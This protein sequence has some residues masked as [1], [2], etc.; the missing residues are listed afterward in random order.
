MAF[1]VLT[2]FVLSGPTNCMVRVAKERE[3]HGMDFGLAG[4]K[5][6]HQSRLVQAGKAT[7]YLAWSDHQ[8]D[9]LLSSVRLASS[10][11]PLPSP[12]KSRTIIAGTGACCKENNH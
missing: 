12:C 5:L 2:I 8:K 6:L 7:L 3:P 11:F 4:M 9:I 10:I 1:L